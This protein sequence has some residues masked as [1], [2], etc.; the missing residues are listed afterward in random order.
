[1]N[2][3]ARFC[4]KAEKNRICTTSTLIK[5]ISE[6]LHGVDLRKQE[7]CV[8][9]K[10]FEGEAFD[11]YSIGKIASEVVTQKHCCPLCSG[12]L[13]V[14]SDLGSTVISKCIS[15]GFVDLEDKV[16]IAVD[17]SINSLDS[18]GSGKKRAA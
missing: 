9:I 14:T 6:E 10:G 5:S 12:A 1:V 17:G 15:C 4:S 3:A 8:T 11:L 13:K 18:E 2:L 7:S 16:D